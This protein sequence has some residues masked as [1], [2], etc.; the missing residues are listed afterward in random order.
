MLKPSRIDTILDA[1]AYLGMVIL[2]IY[3][4]ACCLIL[5]IQPFMGMLP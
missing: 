2:A 1:C 4:F 5:S 3:A